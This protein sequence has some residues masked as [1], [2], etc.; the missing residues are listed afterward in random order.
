MAEAVIQLGHQNQEIMNRRIYANVRSAK[1]TTVRLT[2]DELCQGRHHWPESAF[3]VSVDGAALAAEL[4]RQLSGRLE[5]PSVILPHRFVVSAPCAACLNPLEIN[6]PEWAL[7][8]RPRCKTC[9]GAWNLRKGDTH[10]ASLPVE[11]HTMLSEDTPE[12]FGFPLNTLG[13]VP[14]TLLEVTDLSGGT[15]LVDISGSVPPT[16]F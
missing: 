5:H 2:Q 12:L 15:C 11:V 13:I 3:K 7:F 1:T 8:S 9:G 4:L 14:G 10:V 6:Q 16:H